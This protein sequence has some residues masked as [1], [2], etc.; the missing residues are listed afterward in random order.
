VGKTKIRTRTW[1][2]GPSSKPFE[3]NPALNHAYAEVN[4]EPFRVVR[5]EINIGIAVDVAGKDG[6]RSLKV[7]NI[8]HA[9][10]L[11]FAQ[12]VQAF[13]DIVARARANKLTILGF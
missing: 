12:Y 4:G 2:D 5:E 13:D 11:D 8:K 7:P 3:S 10:A 6:S 1:W 9:G